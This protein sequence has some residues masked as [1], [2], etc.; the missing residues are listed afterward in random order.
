[1]KVAII[2]T[3]GVPACYGGYETLVEN[4]LDYKQNPNLEYQVYCS[5]KT[6]KKRPKEYKGAKLKYIPFNAN[7]PQSPIYDTISLIHAYFTCDQILSLGT[8]GSFILP[9]MKLFSKKKVIFNLDGLDNERE[10]FSS[11]NQ[12]IIGLARKIAAKYGDVCISDNQ[13]I[14]DYAMNV[15][16]KDSVLIEY[17][18]DQA[19]TV[20]D[21][22]KLKEKYGLIPKG[23][24]FKVARIE[25]ENNIRTILQ[26]YSEMPD[27][28]LVIV[29]NWM[30]S[31]FGRTMKDQYSKFK[32]I[33]ILDP[34]YEPKEINLLR[35]NCKLY[36]HGHSAGGT[37]PSLVE[38]MN[39]GLPI[40]ANGVVYNRE[41]TENKAIYF[42]NHDKDS[43]KES[44]ID[45]ATNP[46]LLQELSD[47][48]AEIGKRRY[49][50]K[51]ICALYEK[52]FSPVS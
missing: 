29:G 16:K 42:E 50:W 7:G 14:K 30:K 33:K 46:I 18:G 47:I 21:D 34:V 39:L 28:Q 25:P 36:I 12:R 9:F 2:G 3:V 31:D 6:Y 35:S 1:M 49:I 41:T 37:N 38:A 51:R 17:G 27:E 44:I 52:L 15:Y 13:G 22:R 43:L 48:M 4:L 19:F 32:N 24:S 23:Y 8:V 10:K 26:A 40:I 20:K 11:F 5:A 45:T